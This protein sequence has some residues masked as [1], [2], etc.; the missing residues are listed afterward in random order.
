MAT[1]DG[2]K[3]NG[4][5]SVLSRSILLPPLRDAVRAALCVQKKHMHRVVRGI[6]LVAFAICPPAAFSGGGVEIVS[7]RLPDGPATYGMAKLVEA[8]SARGISV[9]T[10]DSVEKATGPHVVVAGLAS[11]RQVAELIAAGRT[12]LPEHP[13]ALSVRRIRDGGRGVVVLCGGGPVG[14]M[15]A[16]LDT[17]DRIG[18]ATGQDDLFVHVASTSE[19][20]CLT[21]RAV[22]TYTMQRRLFEQRLYDESYWEHSFDMLARSRI[23]SYVIVF[24]YENG[25]FMAP[26]YPYF[27]D[28][29]E[30]PGVHLCG[31]TEEQQ[32]RNTA[33]LRR[34]IQLAHERGIRVTAG[35]W[36]HIYRGGVQAGGI[37][38]ASELAGHKAPHLVYGV[39][40]ENLAPYTKAALRQF[41]T[42]FPNIDGIQFRMHWESGLTR[43]ETPTFWREVFSMLRDLQPDV[44]IDLRAK[45]L[46]DE[47]IE[48]AVAQGL[49]FRIARFAAEVRPTS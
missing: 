1:R 19:S 37:A 17:A 4:I 18:W 38:G 16:A 39:T 14:L 43:E 9:T 10:A 30:F 42:V 40:A 35:I 34:V 23:N 15:Y 45:G 28:V 22:S 25:G 2:R 41:L 12:A 11:D 13:E 32:A 33:S 21:D 7:S 27:F 26:V 47:V 8:I 48:D 20:P 44:Q 49:H 24:G 5:A 29:E 31:I 6:V 46:P 36:D 3:G